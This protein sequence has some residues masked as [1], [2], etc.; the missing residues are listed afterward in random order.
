MGGSSPFQSGT[1]IRIGS[2]CKWQTMATGRLEVAFPDWVCPQ[3]NRL[4][5][6]PQEL[7]T[8][9]T[10]GT[11]TKASKGGP[12]EVEGSS[13]PSSCLRGALALHEEGDLFQPAEHQSVSSLQGSLVSRSFWH[14]PSNYQN[15][16]DLNTQHG[17]LQLL[18][19]QL[20]QGQSWCSW[21]QASTLSQ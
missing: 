13:K 11:K 5:R 1:G 21:V 15:F 16:H 12:R 3:S 6:L 8:K 20:T 18:I 10:G 4:P 14:L 7:P 17:N 19:Q 9:N 2:G